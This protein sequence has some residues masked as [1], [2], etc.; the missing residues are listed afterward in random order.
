MPACNKATFGAQFIKKLSKTV[1]ELKKYIFYTTSVYVKG[2]LSN[3]RSSYFFQTFFRLENLQIFKNDMNFCLFLYGMLRLARRRN[4][5][6]HLLDT[7]LLILHEMQLQ[8]QLQGFLIIQDFVDEFSLFQLVLARFRW[9][10][11]V[12]GSFRSFQVVLAQFNFFCTLEVLAQTL[13]QKLSGTFNIR[14]I[15]LLFERRAVIKNSAI[16]TFAAYSSYLRE[17]LRLQTQRF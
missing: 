4:L 8:M 10:Q 7:Q 15:Q 14:S 1:A 9:F 6:F 13:N 5:T 2:K 16:F 3:I 11:V 17:E 12:L